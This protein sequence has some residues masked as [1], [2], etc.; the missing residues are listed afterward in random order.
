MKISPFS[1]FVSGKV[2]FKLVHI[3]IGYVRL[4]NIQI[5]F[6]RT[7]NFKFYENEKILLSRIS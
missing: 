4:I 1:S 6:S 2:E 3:E 5:S 7:G